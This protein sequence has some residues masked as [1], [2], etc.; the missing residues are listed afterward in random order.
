VN[1][2]TCLGI[3][4]ADVIVGT[5]D[6]LP[7]PG[8]LGLVDGIEL[9]G[10]GCALN[11]ASTLARLGDRAAVV[12]KVGADP[13]GD[14]LLHLLDER[15]VDRSGV[16]SDAATGTSASVVIVDGDGERTFLHTPGANAALSAEELDLAALYDTRCLHAAGA[17]L[18][19][20]LDGEPLARVL[21][22]ARERGVTTSIDTAWDAKG[23]W[24]RIEACLPHVDVACPN[25]A[26][27]RAV[28]GLDDAAAVAAWFRARGP[29]WVTLTM[30]VDG[31]YASGPG[32]DGH[33]AAPR[34][35]VVDST[36][37]GDAFAGGLL[38][39]RLAGWDL[40]RAARFACAAGALATTTR[41]ASSGTAGLAET[42][43]LTG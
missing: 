12:G 9:H 41:G 30:G 35:H 31:C 40:E 19:E 21:A 10:G 32:F 33:V 26:E 20:R 16:V 6:E 28:S 29:G 15:G 2:V 18:L 4:V 36:G 23:R 24:Q 8:S 42:I 14:H 43:A 22:G 5:V 11:A 39:A 1:D 3:L 17:G 25:V 38:H 37:A 13:F 7:A 34:V 27:A